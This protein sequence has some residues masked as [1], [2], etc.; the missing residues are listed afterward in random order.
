MAK[1]SW[2]FGA[3]VAVQ[4]YLFSSTGILLSVLLLLVSAAVLARLLRVYVLDK[5]R[6]QVCVVCPRVTIRTCVPLLTRVVGVCRLAGARRRVVVGSDHG[7]VLGVWSAGRCVLGWT[8]D[9][10]HH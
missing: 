4:L 1:P 5:W 6:H 8:D 10:R 7:H 3:A 9:G 2:L